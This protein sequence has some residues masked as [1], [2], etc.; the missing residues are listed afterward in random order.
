MYNEIEKTLKQ[1]EEIIFKHNY[2]L[3]WGIL[4]YKLERHSSYMYIK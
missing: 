2:V 3:Q 4:F 1:K